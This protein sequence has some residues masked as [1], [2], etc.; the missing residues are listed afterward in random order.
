MFHAGSPGW[1]TTPPAAATSKRSRAPAITKTTSGFVA[2]TS[3]VHCCC[4]WPFPPHW[5]SAGA[6]VARMNTGTVEIEQPRRVLSHSTSP[7]CATSPCGPCPFGEPVAS[8]PACD[9]PTTSTR[10][11]A[12]GGGGGV[13]ASASVTA[14]TTPTNDATIRTRSRSHAT[15][16]P[17]PPMLRAPNLTRWPASRSSARRRPP[18]TPRSSTTGCCSS[19]S[20]SPRPSVGR[21]SP[22]VCVATTSCVPVRDR[23]SLFV[24]ERLDLAAVGAAL[25]RPTVV[26]ADAGMVALALDRE[27][28]TRRAAGARGARV[29]AARPRRRSAPAVAVARAEAA[30][31]RLLLLVRLPLRPAR[32]AGHPRRAAL[33]GTSP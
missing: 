18:S 28:A 12:G 19:R 16:R 23:A 21:S 22:R 1:S 2:I 14:P 6:P 10:N 29:H 17:R 30:A 26:D 32:V 13:R 15:G 5:L 31:P 33:T 3:R 4:Q 20:C 24:G 27:R 9:S 11:R 8:V 25:G 7:G